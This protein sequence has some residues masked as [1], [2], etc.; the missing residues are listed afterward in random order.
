LG[1]VFVTLEADYHYTTVVQKLLAKNV[2]SM[3]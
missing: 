3:F 1:F 2:F